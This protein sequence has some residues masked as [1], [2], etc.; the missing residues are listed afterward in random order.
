MMTM[1]TRRRCG[2]RY[3]TF[4]CNSLI[5]FCSCATRLCSFSSFEF[6]LLISESFL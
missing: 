5:F 3:L 2:H 6:K 1:M 4:T